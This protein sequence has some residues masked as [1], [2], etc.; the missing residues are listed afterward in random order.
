MD[1]NGDCWQAIG[2][3]VLILILLYFIFVVEPQ[4]EEEGHPYNHD[5]EMPKPTPGTGLLEPINIPGVMVPNDFGPGNATTKAVV[6]IIMH[7]AEIAYWTNE[8][9]GGDNGYIS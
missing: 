3:I 8:A 9:M 7:E 1:P 2:A 6:A 4:M 5:Q